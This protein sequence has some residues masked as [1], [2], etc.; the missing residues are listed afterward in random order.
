MARELWKGNEA[1]AE[2]AIR[3]GCDAY[4]GYPI[5]PQSELIEYMSFHMPDRGRVFLQGESEIAVVNMLY[6]A[7]GS[8]KRVMTS[9]S[10][11]GIALMQEG[12][13]YLAGAEVPCVI[14]NCMRG[15]PGLGTIQPSQADYY[16]M[17]RGGASGDH[18][19]IA[20]A[21][22]NIQEA[23]DM[24]QE[25]FDIAMEYRN[26][27]FV[28]VDGLIGQMMEPIEWHE[29][30]RRELP[31]VDSWAANGSPTHK[32]NVINSLWID[33]DQDEAFNHR[34]TQKTHLMQKNEVRY[35]KLEC[36][37][38][39]IVIVAYGTPARVSIS[40][41]KELRVMGIKAGLFRPKTIWPYPYKALREVV[42][43]ECVKKILCVELS[44]GQMI[45]DVEIA[46]GDSKPIEF[47]GHSGGVLFATDELVDHVKGII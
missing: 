35:E 46:V 12:L 29:I 39:E 24:V 43:Q 9:S 41:V 31:D 23:V 34:L 42:D 14:I 47:Y 17:T 18:H 16:Q 25:A 33:A 10:S 8:G 5:T 22:G 44:E 40:A 13:S 45:D 6:G 11:V 38:A 1:M 7:G 15:G 30:P 32:H 19:F 4:F 36:D 27:V 26:P 21:P 20:L 2:A 3:A 28:V 37:D